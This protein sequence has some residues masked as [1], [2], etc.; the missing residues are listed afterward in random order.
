[1][2]T[3]EPELI[4]V[5]RDDWE[6]VLTRLAR[7]EANATAPAGESAQ[8]A[9]VATEQ[10]SADED[11]SFPRRKLLAGLSRRL[12]SIISDVESYSLQTG[13]QRVIGYFLRQDDALGTDSGPA[14]LTLPVSKAVV[15]SR[16]NLTPE[17]FSRILHDLQDA[18]KHRRCDDNGA[19]ASDDGEEDKDRDDEIAPPLVSKRPERAV[20]G[21]DSGGL[22]VWRCRDQQVV[23]SPLTDRERPVRRDVRKRTAS[24][25]GEVR[26]E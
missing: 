26:P 17:H 16:L 13:T 25:G 23:D 10:A 5:R 18:K 22:A 11:R 20:E 8:G 9:V 19:G 2:D 1:M 4:E 3:N 24:T 21:A 15:A 12:H 7:L 6:A 14:K